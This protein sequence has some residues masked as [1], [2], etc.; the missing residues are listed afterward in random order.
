MTPHR[1]L[2]PRGQRILLGV[3]A[4][5]LM[6]GTGAF[7]LVGAWPVGGFAGLEL[8]AAIAL[9]RWHARRARAGELV[10]MTTR[11][12]RIIR[13]DGMGRRRQRILPVAWLS[14]QIEER[15]GRPAALML[16]GHGVRQEIATDLGEAERRDLAAALQAALHRLRN[17]V[18]ENDVLRTQA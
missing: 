9:F 3:L 4:G 18:F 14:A 1:S 11:D 7:A 12:I 15:P 8:L 17:P 6:L 2:S 5:L 10:I 16:T 13:T